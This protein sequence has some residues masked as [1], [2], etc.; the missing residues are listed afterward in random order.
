M[1][2]LKGLL[3]AVAIYGCVLALVYIG[4]R[5]L[6]YHPDRSRV[7][8]AQ[9]GLPAAEEL[10]LKSADGETVIVW[11]V[12]PKGDRPVVLYFHGNGGSLAWRANRFRSFTAD[13]TGLVAL[14][15]RG[16]G[17]SPRRPPPGGGS[18]AARAPP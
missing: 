1:V 7:T 15:Y 11:H 12:P 17:G 18:A 3:A 16:Y 5:S 4:Q 8:P 14:S 10:E 2:L 6:Q 9:A 13:G